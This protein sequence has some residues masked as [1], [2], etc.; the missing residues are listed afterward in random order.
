MSSDYGFGKIVEY[1]AALAKEDIILEVNGKTTVYEASKDIYLMP[2]FFRGDGCERTGKC[3][4][5]YTIAFTEEGH[6]K[7]LEATQDDFAKYFLPMNYY[8]DLMASIEIVE[9]TINGNKVKFYCD[10]PKTE[11][12]KRKQCDH[13]FYDEKGLSYCGIQPVKSITCEFP[14][15]NM[16]RTQGKTYIRKQQFGR[17]HQLGC[18]VEFCEFNY[19]KFKAID[20]PLFKRLKAI[21]DDMKVETYIPELLAIFEDLDS[22]LSKGIIPKDKIDVINYKKQ[23]K[24]VKLF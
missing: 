16:Y 1:V 15:N 10:P 22:D 24:Q 19:L 20:I 14:H 13:L 11:S 4:R 23:P 2:I 12:I 9:T 21:A 6:K 3:C 17:N 7:I 8:E 18:P 5:H